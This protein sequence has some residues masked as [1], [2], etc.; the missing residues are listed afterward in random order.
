VWFDSHCHAYDCDGGGEAALERARRAGVSGALVAGV[1]E[2]TSRRA[3]ALAGNGVAAAAGI[4]PNSC[5][6]WEEAW[7]AP[8]EELLAD[9][10]VAATGE[11]GLDFY[12]DAA[13]TERQR[14]SFAAHIALA[15][16]HDVALVIH[17]RASVDAA[18]EMLE[19]LGP[20]PRLVF[21]CWSGD[22]AQM[23]RALA[24]GAFVSFAGN[25]T[26]RSA[27]VLREVAAQV[28]ED[29]LLVETDSP[30]LAPVPHRG[31]PNE[32]AHVALVGCAVAEA[33]GVRAEDVARTTSANAR[34]M[35]ALGA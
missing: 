19:S 24:L 20:P 13:P 1:D 10:R 23:R 30:Y 9:E 35:L 7:M 11:T 25:V 27:S 3:L 21:H 17:T 18:L 22:G 32:P 8:I 15:R 12:R 28:P 29:R 4:H 2:D 34:R 14:A 6:G 33:R 5:A 31:E 26:F 16:T